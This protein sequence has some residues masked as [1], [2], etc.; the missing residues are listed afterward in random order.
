MIVMLPLIGPTNLW[1][2]SRQNNQAHSSSFGA[3]LTSSDDWHG[4]PEIPQLLV[5]LCEHDRTGFAECRRSSPL[6]K[7]R[8]MTEDFNQRYCEESYDTLGVIQVF[9]L[10]YSS[11]P[12]LDENALMIFFFQSKYKF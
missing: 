12:P 8:T 2:F 7:C 10:T 11:V 9:T 1:V 6:T 3:L 5:F 4:A